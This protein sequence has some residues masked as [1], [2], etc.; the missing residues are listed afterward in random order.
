M[1]FSS[2]FEY[3]YNKEVLKM[4]LIERA[5]HAISGENGGPSVETIIGIA[6][7]LLVG[8]A[9]IAFGR[10]MIAWI[11]KAQNSVNSMQTGNLK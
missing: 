1:F 8:V 11:G 6:V 10:A 7:A 4:K 5:R 2:Q 3:Y 9:L